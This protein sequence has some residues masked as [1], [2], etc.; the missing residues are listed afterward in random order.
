[1]STAPNS[2]RVMHSEVKVFNSVIFVVDD[3]PEW[4]GGKERHPNALGGTSVVLNF[5]VDDVDAVHERA[6]KAGFYFR[7]ASEGPVLGRPLHS[8]GGSF[9]PRVGL[10]DTLEGRTRI[11]AKDAVW[12]GM[13]R[14]RKQ[15]GEELIKFVS[16]SCTSF[17]C[18]HAFQEPSV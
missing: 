14:A 5:A 11:M 1:M 12:S 2:D 9:R 10:C 3:F 4:R 7:D 18:A 17:Y 8:C 16:V 13:R 15:E 6:I